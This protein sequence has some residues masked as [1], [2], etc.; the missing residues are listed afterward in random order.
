MVQV[1]YIRFIALWMDIWFRH[2]V[3]VSN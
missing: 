3:I 1:G 2:D